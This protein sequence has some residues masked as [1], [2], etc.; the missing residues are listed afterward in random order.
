MLM[1]E[2]YGQRTMKM[3]KVQHFPSVFHYATDNDNNVKILDISFIFMR[4]Q[5]IFF[6]SIVIILILSLTLIIQAA[7]YYRKIIKDSKNL[8]KISKR[9][10]KL[11]I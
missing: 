11:K 8:L 9:F 1:M 2:R 10:N 3:V 5:M 7:Y 6:L 4:E